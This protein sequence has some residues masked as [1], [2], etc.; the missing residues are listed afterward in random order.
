V[1]ASSAGVA[2]AGNNGFFV[3]ATPDGAQAA[4]IQGPSTMSIYQ[5]VSGFEVGTAYTLA[6]YLAKRTDGCPPCGATIGDALISAVVDGTTVFGP[7]NVGSVSPG[8]QLFRSNVF[9]A[10]APTLTIVFE[11]SGPA[12]DRT[13]FVDAVRIDAAVPEPGSVLLVGS[14]ALSLLVYCRR[15]AY[16]VN[17]G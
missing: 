14:G 1:F 12:G 5:N 11:G 7:F 4:F 13:G 10:A 15:R 9:T 3:P 6:F 2:A 17:A 16:R 8:F